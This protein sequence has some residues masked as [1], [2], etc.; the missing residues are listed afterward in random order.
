MCARFELKTDFESYKTFENR[1]PCG[2]DIR[3]K[4]QNLIRPTDLY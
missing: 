1:Y 4:P 3:Y 2:L